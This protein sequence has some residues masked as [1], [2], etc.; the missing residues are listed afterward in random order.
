MSFPRMGQIKSQAN[1]N[2]TVAWSVLIQKWP[3]DLELTWNVSLK[4]FVNS[5]QA[6][7]GP[8]IETIKWS[9]LVVCVILYDVLSMYFIVVSY[10]PRDARICL[11]IK[12]N[13]SEW[14]GS[15]ALSPS[16]PLGATLVRRILHLD[17]SMQMCLSNTPVRKGSKHRSGVIDISRRCVRPS[18]F[19]KVGCASLLLVH[20]LC[21]HY[22]RACFQK[23]HL[24]GCRY[25][26]AEKLH[27]LNS[28]MIYTEQEVPR[29]LCGKVC[30]NDAC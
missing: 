24:S 2:A 19:S 29:L 13:V 27:V 11:N 21:L 26:P 17:I 5:N 20:Q 6:L 15:S 12:Y 9:I 28:N 4:T 16:V 10:L 7:F 8:L 22:C 14:N 18:L 3:Q 25:S 30:L 1:L 23:H